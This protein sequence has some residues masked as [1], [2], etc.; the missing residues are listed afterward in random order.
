MKVA[1]KIQKPPLVK[2]AAKT[3]KRE[4]NAT[5]QIKTVMAIFR[6]HFPEHY[7]PK[8]QRQTQPTDS[9]CDSATTNITTPKPDNKQTDTLASPTLADDAN[10]FRLLSK[11]EYHNAFR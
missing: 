10:D 11:S 6:E 4:L 7:P 5:Q 3:K 9:V 2:P 1:A 8:T